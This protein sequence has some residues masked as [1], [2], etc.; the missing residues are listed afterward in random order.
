[1]ITL[2]HRLKGEAGEGMRFAIAKHGGGDGFHMPNLAGLGIK[3]EYNGHGF[4]VLPDLG[5]DDLE[6]PGH[7]GHEHSPSC[8]SFFD[9]EGHRFWETFFGFHGHWDRGRSEAGQNLS[10][11]ALLRESI[12]AQHESQRGDK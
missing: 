3:L 7:I 9:F 4:S 5:G 6:S 2:V 10:G 12:K 1:M 11:R 8:K